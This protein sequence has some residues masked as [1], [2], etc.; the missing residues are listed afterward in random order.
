[1]MRRRRSATV[2]VL[3]SA[4]VVIGTVGAVSVSASTPPD[5][6]AATTVA[7]SEA[8]GTTAAGSMAPD[9]TAAGSMA[10]GTTGATAE[11]TVPSTEIPAEC[12]TAEEA[13]AEE[14]PATTAATDGTAAAAATTAAPETTVAAAPAT[15]AAAEGTEAP[16]ATF[17]TQLDPTSTQ[18]I[19]RQER[20][21]LQQGGELRLSTSSIANNW[22][23]NHPLGNE[24]DYSQIRDA[25]DYNLWLFDAE[26]NATL[27]TNFVLE[28]TE[29][30][31]GEEPFTITYTLNPEAVWNNGDP[32]DVGDY[33]AYWQA[34][35]GS[36]PC[37]EVV[38]TEGYDL[39]SSVEAGADDFEVVVTFDAVYPDYRA[40]FNGLTPEEGTADSEI[41]NTGWGDLL[42]TS[43][44]WTG[45]FITESVDAVQGVVVQVPNP[46]WWGEAPLLDRIVWRVVSADAVPQAYANNE[47]DSFDIGV[48]PNGFAIA[49]GTPGGVIRAAAGPNWRHYTLNHT[50]GLIADPVVRQAIILGLDRG[51]IGVSDLAGIPWPAQPLGNHILT[52]NQAGYVDNAPAYDPEGAKALLEGDGWV[53]GSDGVYEKDGQ[54]LSITATQITGVPVSENE[55]L[56]FQAQLNEIGFDVSIADVSQ[57]TWS[58]ELVAG[59]FEVLAFTWVGTPFPFRGPGQLY[60]NGS[61]SNFGFSNIPELDPLIDE[62]AITVDV[63]RRTE[64]A[65]EI[66]QILWDNGHTIPLYQRPELVAA[67]ENLANFGAFGYET[68]VIWE[69]VGWQ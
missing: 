5:T 10:P 3:A 35:N 53:A 66:D 23:P 59:N 32:I 50:A 36:D 45:P 15:T 38:A 63:E 65:N 37:F 31:E 21:S 34:L 19:N 26:A 57:D 61:D 16:A 13:A 27:D 52:E 42:A 39:I 2:T 11:S 49:E 18:D 30:P 56:Q 43:D 25:I 44:W 67:N 64:I 6:G 14:A 8:P 68:P 51:E 58:D 29:S 24:L 12:V 41:F 55:A 1:M 33:Q 60:G 7:G 20:D 9:T 40:L 22:N 47:L 48:D 46:N 54:R 62:L 4:A 17:E 28:S 69:N